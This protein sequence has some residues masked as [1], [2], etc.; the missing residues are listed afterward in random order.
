[1]MNFTK[2]FDAFPTPKFL[3]IPFAGISISD[4]AVRCIEFGRKN[5]S[6]Y[7]EK[8]AERAINPGV[9]I[10]G[11]IN[12]AEDIIAVLNDIK[13]SLNLKYVKI[14]LPEEKAYLFTTKI[15]IVKPNEVKNVIESK[16]EDNVPVSPS[17]LTFDFNV[18]SHH[19]DHLDVVVSALPTV[20]I[21]TYID[22]VDKAKLS[23]LSLEI[24]SQ[25]IARAILP[26]STTGTAL[27]VNFEKEKVGLY[28]A[29]DK[30]VRFT[31]TVSLKSASGDNAEYL[32]QEIKKLYAY[33]H[34]LKENID[35]ESKKINKIIICG[36]NIGGEIISYFSA[37]TDTPV[38]YGNIW[39][40]AFDINVF[41]PDISFSDSLRY[42][43]AVG[44]ALPNGVLI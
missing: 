37:H 34:T 27:L 22:M 7:I 43:A 13:K 26:Y 20:V 14:S 16:I 15:P 39:V 33:W 3:D 28:V 29:S 44:L 9:I 19:R 35:K 1:M 42:A 4:S 8:Y 2:I 30:I 40:N 41:V 25:S 38:V 11:Q 12:H 17:E 31:S 18:L 23:L 21:D 32:V 36:E 24:E 5:Q 6:L 10:S